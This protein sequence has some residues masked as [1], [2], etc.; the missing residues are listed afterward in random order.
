MDTPKRQVYTN[1]TSD[2][3]IQKLDKRRP[4][5]S[6]IYIRNRPPPPP[7]QPTSMFKKYIHPPN[8]PKSQK[9]DNRLKNTRQSHPIPPLPCPAYP[10]SHPPW[11][12]FCSPP[13]SPP[14][15]I[16][17]RPNPHPSTHQPLGTY[18][19]DP[20]PPLS[21]RRTAQLSS[22]ARA[23]RSFRRRK[24][25][26]RLMA[27]PP[28]T[29]NPPSPGSAKLPSSALPAIVMADTPHRLRCDSHLSGTR[30][31]ERGKNTELS[32]K[33]QARRS[34]DRKSRFLAVP[35]RFAPFVSRILPSFLRLVSRHSHSSNHN[36]PPNCHSP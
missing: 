11:Y 28:Y 35:V 4:S 15:L 12:Y 32:P 20:R 8:G 21:P 7:N 6:G 2:S 23:L 16:S 13:P 5:S 17:P 18:K 24:P 19:A 3:C 10:K 9:K 26:R 31:G 29:F 27:H 30:W 22:A 36:P 25:S 33:R 14:H 34:F 1:T